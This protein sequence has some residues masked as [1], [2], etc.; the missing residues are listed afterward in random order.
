MATNHYETITASIVAALAAGVKPWARPGQTKGGAD[1]LDAGLPFN[2]TSNK[3]YRGMN[4]P[5]LWAMAYDKGYSRHAWVSSRQA[6]EL[7]GNVK[8]GEK[9]SYVYFSK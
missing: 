2:V 1:M 4:I 8:K 6:G 7:G 5:L 9:A 3:N